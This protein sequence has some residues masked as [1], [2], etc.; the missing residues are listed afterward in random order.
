M[1]YPSPTENLRSEAPRRGTRKERLGLSTDC[2]KGKHFA[3]RKLTSG[4]NPQETSIRLKGDP[5]PNHGD[6]ETHKVIQL[7]GKALQG[8]G[9][10]QIKRGDLHGL[11]KENELTR[12]RQAPCCVPRP[13]TGKSE[14]GNRR[15]RFEKASRQNK[16][17]RRDTPNEI[18]A[19]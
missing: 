15:Q 18:S 13:A 16:T 8:E 6:W 19:Q 17:K 7:R 10:H 12:V 5:K 14:R 3:G 4:G 1:T 11:N 9:T 2:S